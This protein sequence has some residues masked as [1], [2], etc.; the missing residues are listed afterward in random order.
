MFAV[1]ASIQKAS[2]VKVCMYVMSYL[3]LSL[4][5]IP[6]AIASELNA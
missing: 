4:I 6:I 3:V 5:V 2:F 1:N